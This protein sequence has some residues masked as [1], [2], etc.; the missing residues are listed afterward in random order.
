MSKKWLKVD[1]H[2]HT[3]EDPKDNITYHASELIARASSLRFDAIAITNH[4]RV[5]L[6]SELKDQASKF[7]LTLIPGAEITC[8]GKH[9]LILN[10]PFDPVGKKLTWSDLKEMRTDDSLVVAPHPYFPGFKSL[11]Q[12]L[13]EYHYLFDAIE[14]SAFYNN[15]FNP[16]VRAIEASQKYGKP[17]IACS[18]T[19]NLWQLGTSYTLVEAE[20]SSEAIIKAIKKDRIKIWSRP[21]R[22]TTMARIMANFLLADRL[23]LPLH[24]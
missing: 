22:L 1:L 21:L 20:P 5:T 18:D 23:K 24:I 15:F 16:N 14:F 6:N 2:T 13:D 7:N 8:E 9:V 19:H 10:P 17:L 3:R 4:N 12:L 11:F